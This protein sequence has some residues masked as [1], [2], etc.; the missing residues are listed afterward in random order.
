MFLVMSITRSVMWITPYCHACYN[1]LVIVVTI[2]VT[3]VTG[4]SNSN[5]KCLCIDYSSHSNDH[6]K[7]WLLLQFNYN[8]DDSF[9]YLNT[10]KCIVIWSPKFPTCIRWRACANIDLQAKRIPHESSPKVRWCGQSWLAGTEV[11]CL[12]TGEKLATGA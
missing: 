10:F 8:N 5:Y 7:S 9:W 1:N 12:H 3:I 4:V 6:Y 2:T 11:S